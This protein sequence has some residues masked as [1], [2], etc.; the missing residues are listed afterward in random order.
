LIRV[1]HLLS[2]LAI[3]GKER[4]ALRLATQ[5]TRE[6]QRHEMVLFDTPFRSAATDFDPGAVPTHLLQ[7]GGGIDLGF[8][9][10]LSRLLARL[11][12]DVVHAHNDTALVYAVIARRL[13]VRRRPRLVATFHSWPSHPTRAAA[14]LTRAAA[15]DAAVVA[16]SAELGERLK[17]AGWLDD[18][19][20]IWNGVDQVEFAPGAADDAWRRELGVGE[21]DIL[22]G[23]VARFDAIKRHMDLLAAAAL[24]GTAPRIVFVLVG[25]GPLQEEVQGAAAGLA[26]LRFLPRASNIASLLS[27]LDLLVLCSAHEAAPLSLLE[28]MAC[29]VPVV[30]TAVGGMPHMVGAGAEPG[31][32]LTP[33][34]D[35][36]ALAGAIQRLA[37]NPEERS[38]LGAAGLRRAARFSFKAE[39]MAYQALYRGAG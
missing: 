12:S 21:G 7:R 23:H 2:G 4:A 20:T 19:Q 32:L 34:L 6:G 39:W 38:R 29:G 13:L 25:Q 35:P 31:G 27:A 37:N 18:C 26:N 11:R 17:E 5:G 16:V 14:W 24:V 33:P 3:G 10:R 30:A 28:A 1:A 36:V 22:V 15:R 8:A 9:W